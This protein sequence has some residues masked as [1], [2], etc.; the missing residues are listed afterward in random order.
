MK[1]SSCYILVML[2]ALFTPWGYSQTRLDF[3]TPER[4]YDSYIQALRDMD[5]IATWKCLDTE[6]FRFNVTKSYAWQPYKIIKKTVFDSAE[7]AIR[8]YGGI[9]EV[10]LVV[11][12]INGTYK[13]EDLVFLIL[14]GDKWKI[15]DIPNP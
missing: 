1:T 14:V 3:T 13:Y 5:S 15:I 6:E 7:V 12:R 2:Y 11:E 4:T 10:E 8:G 9:G